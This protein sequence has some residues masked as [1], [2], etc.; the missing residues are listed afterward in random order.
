MRLSWGQLKG[1]TV[2]P[3]LPISRRREDT[4]REKGLLRLRANLYLIGPAIFVSQAQEAGPKGVFW[5]FVHGFRESRDRGWR[6]TDHERNSG[7]V[8]E[9]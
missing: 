3:K 2:G 6:Y 9:G 5:L 4:V 7:D 1:L 8:V